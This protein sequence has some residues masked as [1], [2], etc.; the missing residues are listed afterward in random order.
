MKFTLTAWIAILQFS[1]TYLSMLALDTCILFEIFVFQKCI[2][3]ER[4]QVWF[5]KKLLERDSPSL[6]SGP[7]SNQTP[8]FL[9]IFFWLLHTQVY[10]NCYFP[11]LIVFV[12]QCFKLNLMFIYRYTV[13]FFQLSN[14][15]HGDRDRC[16]GCCNRCHGYFSSVSIGL[17]FFSLHGI[18]YRWMPNRCR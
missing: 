13:V 8:P 3:I 17:H 2:V 6:L 16:Y 12:F 4:L 5:S 10:N 18:C 15:G 7:S 11:E 1:Y 9:L 14:S